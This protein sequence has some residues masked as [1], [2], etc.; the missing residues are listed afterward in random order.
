MRL[1]TRNVF[2]EEGQ[3]EFAFLI[4]P[5]LTVVSVVILDG[6]YI[7]ITNSKRG[8]HTEI[9]VSTLKNCVIY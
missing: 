1:F 8:N 5:M 7:T 3:E 4:F 2:N 9:H 6:S